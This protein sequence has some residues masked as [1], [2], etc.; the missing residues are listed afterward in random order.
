M[1]FGKSSV[2]TRT[3][4]G[5]ISDGA[6]Q[7][8]RRW[9]TDI[10]TGPFV[11]QM[12]NAATITRNSLWNLFDTL[13]SFGT[14]L[15]ASIAVARVM[16]PTKLGY[17]QYVVW[18]AM[19]TGTVASLGVPAATR[20]FAAEFLGRG[21]HATARAIIR[22]TMRFQ[23]VVAT[24]VG[25]V[26]LMVVLTYVAPERRLWASLAVLAIVPQ[27]MYGVPAAA[28]TATE[29][30]RPNVRV[31]VISTT[32]HLVMI[33]LTLI[34]RWDLVG[35]TASL[36]TS[37]SVDCVLRYAFYRR[38]WAPMP[39][40][41]QRAPLAPELRTRLIRFCWQSTVLLALDL[42]VWNRSEIFFLERYS[43]ITQV[44][45]Y[46][47]CFNIVESLLVLPRVLAWSADTTILVQQGR[48]PASVARLGVTTLRFMVLFSIP[49]AFGLAALAD[50]AM[51][52]VYGA[53]YLPA[54]PVL[55]V[56]AL[57]SIG[58]AMQLPAQRLLAAT[59]NQGFLVGWG[60]FLALVNV[61]ANLVLI[62]SGGA[63]GAAFSK[64]GVQ[65]IAMVGMWVYA[66]RRLGAEIP[67]GRLTGLIVTAGTMFAV[68]WT[69]SRAL[70]G[71][72]LDLVVGV[73]VGAVIMIVGLRVIGY[74]EPA[75]R[76]RLAP[77]QRMF[78]GPLRSRFAR[79]IEFLS[80]GA[81]A[82]EPA[83]AAGGMS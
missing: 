56:T 70:P 29:D 42:I 11:P 80:P 40:A 24:I 61:A 60:I 23:A 67:A 44:A 57:F 79:L 18:V 72:V 50:P 68:V 31:S 45:F 82:P 62:P 10:V 34:L 52:L 33:T 78:P 26:G 1:L 9:S 32:I 55:M 53:K 46:S 71:S 21:E 54:I 83:K 69:L 39:G 19:M 48:N 73:P 65:V 14:T 77:L 8:T 38:L 17:Y 3:R 15:I 27:L 64:G 76:N 13:L 35:L 47:I 43:A 58:R 30:L 20:K 5:S 41:G 4:K 74:L 75:D 16:G 7:D 28:I 25:A 2:T 37:R 81:P 36:L 66:R 12:S 49:A 6:E 59:E 63:L 22:V 51:R